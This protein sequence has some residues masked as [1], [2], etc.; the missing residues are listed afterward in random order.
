MQ[1]TKYYLPKPCLFC[2]SDDNKVCYIGETS[3]SQKERALENLAD[4]R[5]HDTESHMY[6]HRQETRPE[7][8]VKDKDIFQFKILAQY[9]S[10][11]ARQVG[12]SVEMMTF[13][14][15]ELLNKKDMLN[16]CKIPE[17]FFRRLESK[18]KKKIKDKH[19]RE[20]KNKLLQ[21]DRLV[22]KIQKKRRMVKKINI[23][24]K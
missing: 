24:N 8:T 6:H 21:K 17:M 7:S 5:R 10:A 16:R 9:K 15:Y 14:G 18:V 11:F 3:H 19:P 1:S 2:K 12:E 23:T 13:S 22:M 20:Y 4:S